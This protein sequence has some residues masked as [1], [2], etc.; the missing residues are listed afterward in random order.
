MVNFGP[1]LMA[2]WSK[3]LPLTAGYLSILGPALM[4][5][6]SKMPPPTACYLSLLRACHDGQVVQGVATD[7]WLSLNTGSCPDG[8]IMV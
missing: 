8:I 3:A 4:A 2:G 5:E 1:A 7:C 6:W